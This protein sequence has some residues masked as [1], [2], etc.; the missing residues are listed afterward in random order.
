MAGAMT[1][2]RK[3]RLS[4]R[5]KTEA[6]LMTCPVCARRAAM[7]VKLVGDKHHVWCQ[8]IDRGKCESTPDNDTRS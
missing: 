3:R 7:V 1:N 2:E 5:M 8:W 6:D 4:A